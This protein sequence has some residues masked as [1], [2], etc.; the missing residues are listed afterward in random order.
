MRVKALVLGED[1]RAFL[2]VVRALGRAGVEV[3]AAPIDFTAPALCSRHVARRPWLPYHL[4][5]GGA[6]AGAM[7]EVLA[8]EAY[9]LVIP[10]EPRWW[11]PLLWHRERLSHLARLALPEGPGA[12]AL[13][14]RLATRRL[15]EA[16]GIT[17]PAG[18][19][20]GAGE[21]PDGLRAEF[22]LPLAVTPLRR[23]ADSL[24]RPGAGGRVARDWPQLAALLPATG[25]T[26]LV[27]QVPTGDR[28]SLSLLAEGGRLLSPGDGAAARLVG[29]L[30]LTGLVTLNFAGGTLAAVDLSP[31]AGDPG[32]IRAW[33]SLM[34]GRSLTVSRLS[35]PD[36][37]PALARL[38]L[39][40]RP[41]SPE[42]VGRILKG[43]VGG[44]KGGL[45]L[46]VCQGNICRSPFAARALERRLDWRHGGLRV[47]SAGMLPLDGMA[48]PPQGVQA[49]AELGIS[50]AGHRSAHLGRE[51]AEAASVVICFDRINARAINARYPGL[52]APVLLLGGL[53]GG[54]E[55]ADPFGGDLVTFRECYHRIDQAVRAMAELVAG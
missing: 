55:I 40:A 21:D 26:H 1:A 27:E 51:L 44:G 54:G 53:D 3:H 13:D 9:G 18:R 8:A 2:A 31:P 38:R 25:G 35:L 34:S 46:F 14:D 52:K 15:A 33:F 47:G 49:A 20:L 50:L 45:I 29:A 11:L 36:P 32:L 4:G 42:A 5:D 23:S 37:G 7:E 43:A 19:L 12:A 10:C 22:G 16:A 6:W 28:R 48:P 30:G 24:Y 39:P 41:R 17:V